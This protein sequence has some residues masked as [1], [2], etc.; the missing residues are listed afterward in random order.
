MLKRYLFYH[1][2]DKYREKMPTIK[3]ISELRNNFNEISEICHSEG[4]P[5]FITKNGVGDLVVMSISKYEQIQ[6]LLELYQKLS[7]A[8]AQSISREGRVSHKEMIDELRLR[9]HGKNSKN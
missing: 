1:S 2:N 6:A 5:V 7:V 9:L 8:E 4:E 3:P